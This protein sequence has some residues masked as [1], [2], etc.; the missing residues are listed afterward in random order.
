MSAYNSFHKFINLDQWKYP[1]TTK[2]SVSNVGKSLSKTGMKLK[3]MKRIIMTQN[4]GS[5]NLIPDITVPVA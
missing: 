2:D 3:A 4:P 5:A 1:T